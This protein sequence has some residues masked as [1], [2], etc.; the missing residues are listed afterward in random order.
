MTP[1]KMMAIFYRPQCVNVQLLKLSIVLSHFTPLW[2]LDYLCISAAASVLDLRVRERVTPMT[3][4]AKQHLTRKRLVR[5][6]LRE[7][8]LFWSWRRKIPSLGTNTMPADAL[9][10]KSPEHQQAWYWLC[11]TDN[12]YCCFKVNF[13][14]LGQAKSPIRFKMWLYLIYNL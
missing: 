6:G 2:Y 3:L 8:K 13:T 4:T 5:Q 1:A 12:M 10:P 9:A 7:L 14:Y 11:R